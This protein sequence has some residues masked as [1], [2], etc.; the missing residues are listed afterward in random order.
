M[1]APAMVVKLGGAVI[2]HAGDR[3]SLWRDLAQTAER[4]PIV[5]VHGGG[6][7][8]DRLLARLGLASQRRDGLRITP[9]EHM[10]IIAGVLAGQA[11]VDLV[12]H[13]RGAGAQAVGLSL[14]SAGFEAR[15]AHDGALGLVGELVENQPPPRAVTALLE[16]G[17][18]PVINSIGLSIGLSIGQS[19]AAGGNGTGGIGQTLNVN[20]DDAAVGV[21]QSLGAG[22]LVLLTDVPAVLDDSGAPIARLGQDEIEP[23]IASGV[24][25]GG[26]AA[27]CRAAALAARRASAPVTIA[28]HGVAGVL[29]A[30]E[31]GMAIGTTI[32]PTS[33]AASTAA[34]ATTGGER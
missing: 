18:L 16:A 24:I 28:S 23:L 27:K 14:A 8:V 12:R 29:P 21:A 33:R 15:L 3:G 2:D 34:T 20:G 13:L 11:S 9:P 26:M 10:D 1:T 22:R 4:T 31:R 7:A 17:Q 5:V 6:A 25:S 30:L 19:M 32:L